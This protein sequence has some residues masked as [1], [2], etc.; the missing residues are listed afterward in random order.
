MF[1]SGITG[2]RQFFKKLRQ[3]IALPDP[4]WSYEGFVKLKNADLYEMD[5]MELRRAWNEAEFQLLL[6]GDD[7][8]VFYIDARGN[9]LMARAYLLKR[10][11]RIRQLWRKGGAA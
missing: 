7:D 1:N 5:R 9:P 8:F 10:I 3:T 11:S 2:H 4:L 6:V